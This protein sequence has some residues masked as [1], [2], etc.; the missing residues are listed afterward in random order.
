MVD[1]I[2]RANINGDFLPWRDFLHEG[3][4]PQTQSLHQLSRIRA[5]F[6]QEKGFYSLE[7]GRKE[8]ETRDEMLKNYHKYKKII[9]WFEPDLYDQLQLLQIV[10]WFG[11]QKRDYLEL[12]LIPIKD[13][14]GDSSS[15]EIRKLLVSEE[16]LTQEHFE[17]AQKAWSAFT[18]PHPLF[19]FK[20]LKEELH[21][22]PFLRETVQR[23]LEEFPNRRDGLSRSEYQA[24]FAISKGIVHPNKIFNYSQNSEKRKFMGDIIFWKILDDFIE[25]GLVRSKKSGQKL[26]IQP[27]G[28]EILKGKINYLHVKPIDKW[29]GGSKLKNDSLWCWNI[30]KRAIERY[31]YSSSLASLLKFK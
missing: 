14:L 24:L 29:I 8:F 9:L 1:I 22:F 30:E 25:K 31:Y 27:L 13:Y 17:L 4:V 10:S 19:W 7:K 3:P 6:M 5:D 11:G 21:L 2:K 28:E 23:L 16:P 15:H 18:A 26:E 20:L 12:S